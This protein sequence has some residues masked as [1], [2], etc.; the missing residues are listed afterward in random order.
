MSANQSAPLALSSSLLPGNFSGN[1]VVIVPFPALGDLT[2]YLR[3]GWLFHRAG[4][5]VTFCSN[6]LLSARDYFA[7]LTVVSEGEADLPALAGQFDLVI[8]CFEKFY[9]MEAWSPA[10]AE[11]RNIAFVTAKKIARESG[12][13]GREVCVQQHRFDGASRA[14]CLDSRA[15]KT[16][17]DW[18][19][20][21]AKEVFGLQLDSTDGLLSLSPASKQDDLVL[22]FPTTPQAKKNYWLR[23][24]SLLGSV[25]QQR[26]W[27]V[28]FVCVPAEHESIQAA[29]PSFQV[30]SF[31]DIKALMDRVASAAAVISNDSGG[32]HLASMLGVATFTITR[33]REKF[34]WRPGFSNNNTV[35]YPWFRFKWLD[36]K[37]VWRPFVPVWRIATQLGQRKPV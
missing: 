17:V 35:L 27:Q 29:L 11:P 4:A 6:A 24:F 23:G 21:Y 16:M 19:D 9:R 3:L 13:D 8:A 20:S 1:R 10:F 18:V 37:Y 32:G 36:K 14:F 2:I 28:E 22:I 15:G 7:W 5:Q 34:V 26:G 33:R 25:L 30:S 12:L 31:P